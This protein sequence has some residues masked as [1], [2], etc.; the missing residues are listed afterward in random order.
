MQ[1]L[2][3]MFVG[4]VDEMIESSKNT[5]DWYRLR[6]LKIYIVDKKMEEHPD[7]YRIRLCPLNDRSREQVEK[8]SDFSCLEFANAY[9]HQKYYGQWIH[10]DQLN[11]FFILWEPNRNDR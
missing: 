9:T 1:N 10:I 6:R 8:N 4:D 5:G 2:K 11:K 3:F 7:Y